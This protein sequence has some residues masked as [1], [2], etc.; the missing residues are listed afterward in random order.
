M[1]GAVAM[2][3]QTTVANNTHTHT[4]YLSLGRFDWDLG[5]AA[6]FAAHARV[7]SNVLT[8]ACAAKSAEMNRT[9]PLVPGVMTFHS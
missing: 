1:T 9:L 6:E 8:R 7:N 2:H 4:W 3:T 5:Y